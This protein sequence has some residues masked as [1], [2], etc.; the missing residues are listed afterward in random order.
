MSLSARSPFRRLAFA[1]AAAAVALAAAAPASAQEQKIGVIDTERVLTASQVGKQALEGLTA[2]RQQKQQQG[3]ALE[4]ELT[5]LQTRLQEGRM[6][7]SADKLAELQRQAE[8]KALAMRRFQDD[9]NRELAAKRDEV[10]AAVDQ[11]VMPVIN[12]YGQAN[13]YDMI[14]RKFESGLIFVDEAIDVTDEVIAQLD[15]AGGA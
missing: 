13:G 9:A 14:F 4:K 7:L 8:D 6:S 5:D 15:A 3:E 11:K 1:A 10:L 2:L 12:Q